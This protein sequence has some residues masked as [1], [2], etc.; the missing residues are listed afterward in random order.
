MSRVHLH[1]IALLSGLY[2][3]TSANVTFFYRGTEF[4]MEYEFSGWT[5]PTFDEYKSALR[6]IEDHDK[7][8]EEAIR[9]MLRLLLLPLQ[10]EISARI[11]ETV[12]PGS[13]VSLDRLLRAPHVGILV[14]GNGETSVAQNQVSPTYHLRSLSLRDIRL[15][16]TAYL[17]HFSPSEV[18]FENLDPSIA[19]LQRKVRL[20]GNKLAFFKPVENG[21]HD[22]ILREICIQSAM[23]SHGINKTHRVSSL[24]GLVTTGDDGLICGLLYNYIEAKPL[25]E[26]DAT[27]KK[28]N[29][30]RWR[31]RIAQFLEALHSA[32]EAWGDVNDC[33]ILIDDAN[34]GGNAW[35]I[36][37]GGKVGTDYSI[38]KLDEVQRQDWV[39]L[40]QVFGEEDDDSR[41]D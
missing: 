8:L 36:D 28:A 21:R 3:E 5:T 38:M 22:E 24:L 41:G 31:Q 34:D 15:S 10:E 17:P 23:Q 4:A 11:D 29:T 39:E 30:R 7:E 13:A 26:I 14:D 27:K 33:N 6:P 37:F 32:G 9:D 19:S 18:V 35:P 25:V 16:N 2:D 1:E 12:V 20:S 40:R